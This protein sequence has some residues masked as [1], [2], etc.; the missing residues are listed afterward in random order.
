MNLNIPLLKK[1]FEKAKPLGVEITNKFYEFLFNDY[2]QVKPLFKNSDFSKQKMNL[3]NSLV[4][5][6]DHLEKP[7][8]LST[9]LKDMGRR[10]VRYGTEEGHYPAVGKTLLKTFAHFFGE[11]WT[12][13][14][15]RE[16][17]NAY[18]LITKW[19]VEGAKEFKPDLEFVKSKAKVICNDLLLQTIQEEMDSEFI[20]KVREEVRKVL[21]QV[22]DEESEKLFSKKAS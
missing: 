17:S 10:H 20:E 11:D 6:V 8:E 21:L 1:S 3:L 16:W 12:E 19:M 15:N 7:E 18:T 4:Y 2:P 9:Y 5:I 13:E 14:L 22:L